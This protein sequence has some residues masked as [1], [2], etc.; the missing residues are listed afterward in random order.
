MSMVSQHPLFILVGPT[1]VG[2]TEI[3]IDI[4]KRINGEII[5]GDSMQ[6]YKYLDIGTAKI[7]P[8]ETQGINHHLINIKEPTESYS[9]AEFKKNC[10][11]IISD[12]RSKGK[13]PMI[14]GGTGLYINSVINDYNF[15]ENTE[16]DYVRKQLREI[17]EAKGIVPLIEELKI[18]DPRSAKKFHANDSRR[19][20]RALEVCYTTGKPISSLHNTAESEN[21]AKYNFLLVGLKRER[22]ILYERINNRVDEMLR[23]G[24]IR[25]VT[26]LLKSGIPRSAPALQGLG[27]K[28][29]IMYINGELTLEKAVELIKRDTRHF[30]KRQLTWFKKDKRISW[31]NLD[32]I[33]KKTA[34]NEIIQMIG[35]S[36][37]Y[38][39]EI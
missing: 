6:V 17:V 16:A 35:R 26:D 1:G 7:K 9:A 15:I 22:E 11:A 31:I 33:E 13:L 24:W 32:N 5:S 19:I 34:V 12:I 8:E 4:A 36:I 39:V 37:K 38:N 28:Q 30:A 14:V 3:S 18:V 27:Y 10:T 20:I 25:E 23:E 29:L 2:K 21:S